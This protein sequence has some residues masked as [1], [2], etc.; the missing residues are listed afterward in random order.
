MM[1][2]V[3]TSIGISTFKKIGCFAWSRFSVRRE[4]ARILTSPFFSFVADAKT[5][6]C[7]LRVWIET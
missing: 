5:D 4:S 3:I 6:R 2:L 1:G 7:L